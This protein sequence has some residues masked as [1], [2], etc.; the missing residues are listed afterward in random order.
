[1]D[2]YIGVPNDRAASIIGVAVQ[3]LRRWST[4][5]LVEP[6]AQGQV[7]GRTYASH[8]L[9]DLVQGRMVREIE[10]QGIH[11]RRIRAFVELLRSDEHTRPLTSL[12]WG[13]EG[14]DVFAQYPDGSWVGGRKPNQFVLVG[15]DRPLRDPRDCPPGCDLAHRSAGR[16]GTSA[17]R[18]RLE[19]SLCRY[20][21]PCWRG[22]GVRRTRLRTQCDLGGVPRSGG[23]RCRGGTAATGELMGRRR[24]P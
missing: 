22:P 13:T 19:R 10:D 2:E 5:G 20:S 14:P 11:I 9:D 18:A 12:E 3:R 8:G 6:S 24:R 21:H 1:M 23:R 17:K 15:R 7:G 16:R 4:N